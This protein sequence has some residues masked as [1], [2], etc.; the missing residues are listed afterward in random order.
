MRTIRPLL[1]P[2][3]HHL[4]TAIVVT[5]VFG[6]LCPTA[7]RAA[8]YLPGDRVVTTARVN[9]RPEP[10]MNAQPL[11]TL[12][13]GSVGTI[14]EGPRQAN[15]YRFWRIV[16]DG[17]VEGWCVTS[18]LRPYVPVEG[19]ESPPPVE[20]SAPE[21]A[22][23][24]KAT[25]TNVAKSPPR[26][27][28]PAPSRYLLDRVEDVP[29][30]QTTKT[31]LPLP[32]GPP[33]AK[34][35]PFIHP[36]TGHRVTRVTDVNDIPPHHRKGR[37]R[38]LE[39]DGHPDRGFYNGYSRWTNVNVTG[40][41]TI[42]FRHDNHSALYR[43]ADCAYQGP[44]RASHK[45]VLGKTHEI[46]WDRSGRP[47][48]ETTIYY[49]VGG[50]FLRQDVIKGH[51]TA[52]ALYD[53]GKNIVPTVEMDSDDGARYWPLRL[54]DGMCVVFDAETRRMLPGT[55]KQRPNTLDISPLGE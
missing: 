38:P 32:E 50:R 24:I 10:T 36:E 11:G 40:E 55:I 19:E 46:R 18:R 48:T 43:L 45:T 51:L 53:F 14:K 54:E 15:N 42:A 17:G 30:A 4:V 8:R 9:A 37:D 20:T 23:Q 12:K 25:A 35:E 5:A 28:G 21:K 29:L 6:S 27:L 22:S 34:G 3:L 39:F 7:V 33:P 47:G 16:F 13:S 44:V 26:A 1:G 52:E 49:H 41:Y 31:A 2:R